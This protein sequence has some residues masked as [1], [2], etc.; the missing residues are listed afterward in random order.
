MKTNN[1]PDIPLEEILRRLELAGK[2][3]PAEFECPVEDKWRFVAALLL[4]DENIFCRF[5][6]LSSNKRRGR[7]KVS[8]DTKKYNPEILISLAN[9]FDA[10]YKKLCEEYI[11]KDISVPTQKNAIKKFKDVKVDL[12]G[13]LPPAP[14]TIERLVIQGRAMKSWPKIIVDDRAQIVHPL[15]ADVLA[16]IDEAPFMTENGRSEAISNILALQFDR[17]GDLE[18]MQHYKRSYMLRKQSHM[19]LGNRRFEMPSLIKR[20][21]F[22]TKN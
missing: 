5:K 15:Q 4:Q 2:W 18:R 17:P 10:F 13:W 1:Y 9:E 21:K 19:M 6:V 7:K 12:L 22:S 16:M 8:G 14:T 3:L 11:R 20:D